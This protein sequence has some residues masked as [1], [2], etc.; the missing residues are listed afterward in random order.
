MLVVVDGRGDLDIVTAP[1]SEQATCPA[2]LHFA[3]AKVL[4]S[5]NIGVKYYIER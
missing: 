4:R 2:E 1:L 5:I 3:D